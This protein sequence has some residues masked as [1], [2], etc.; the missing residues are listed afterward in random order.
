M[1]DADGV[2]GLLSTGESPVD[3]SY[4]KTELAAWTMVCNLILNLDEV[5]TQH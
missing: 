1:Q 2:E 5:L 3:E 4:D